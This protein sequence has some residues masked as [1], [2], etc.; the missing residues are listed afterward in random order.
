[1]EKKCTKC[2]IEMNKASLIGSGV[3]VLVAKIKKGFNTKVS[4]IDTYV[5][6]KCGY[7]ELFAEKPEIFD[8]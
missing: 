6:P 3:D 5:C 8:K 7:I 4:C 1:M 2:D